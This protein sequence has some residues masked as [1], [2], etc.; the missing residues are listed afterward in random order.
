[1]WV[2]YFALIRYW[3]VL[4]KRNNDWF[5][6]ILFI[7]DSLRQCFSTWVPRNPEVPPI[8]CWVPWKSY[9]YVVLFG[10]FRFRQMIINFW[11]VPRLEKGWKTLHYGYK[12]EYTHNT[13]LKSHVTSLTSRLSLIGCSLN[14]FIF[15]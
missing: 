9:K 4:F 5:D 8:P 12:Y 7:N 11:E 14:Y 10:A 13:F 6:L 3:K 1:M 2:L 15:Y